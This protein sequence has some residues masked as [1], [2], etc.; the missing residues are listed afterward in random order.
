MFSRYP[1][2]ENRAAYN[3]M[4]PYNCIGGQ[5]HRTQAQEAKP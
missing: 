4:K 5:Q 3:C 2:L 1:Y